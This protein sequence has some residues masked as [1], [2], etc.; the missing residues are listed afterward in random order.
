[1]Q[2]HLLKASNQAYLCFTGFIGYHQLFYNTTSS[3]WS[4]F[5]SFSHCNIFKKNFQEGYMGDIFFLSIFMSENVSSFKKKKR[6]WVFI[7][8]L[9]YFHPHEGSTV[10]CL[11]NSHFPL[12]GELWFCQGNPPFSQPCTLLSQL[13]SPQKRLAQEWACDTGLTSEI[14]LLLDTVMSTCNVWD[15]GTIL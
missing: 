7:F 8:R 4:C 15:W 10:G 6:Q 11:P 5:G 13:L 14:F 9:Q 12:L 2:V 3:F 1:M